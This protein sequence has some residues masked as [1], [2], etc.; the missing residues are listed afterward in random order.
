MK[1]FW[2]E[3]YAEYDYA[4]G[5][6]PNDYLKENYSKIPKGKVLF[7]AEGEGRNAVFLAKLGY[8]VDAFD[9]SEEGKI[10]ADK[11]AKTNHTKINYQVGTLETLHYPE[12]SFDGL[13]LIFAHIGFQIRKKFHQD[14]LKLV[15]QNGVII[16]E[17]FSK[18]QL[19]YQSGGPK[20]LEMLFSEAEIRDEFPTVDF[21]IL[22]TEIID[23]NEGQFHQ[24]KGTVVRFIGIKK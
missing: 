3:R 18:E 15:K 5:E 14:L 12:Q 23:L 16:F 11:L 20:Q 1:E 21:N 6:N 9:I 7:P 2:N 17:A 19:Q 24:G 4:Y 13:V 10:K 8:E 22:S